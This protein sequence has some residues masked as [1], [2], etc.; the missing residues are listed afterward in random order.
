MSEMSTSAAISAL[1][2]GERIREQH[3]W[4]DSECCQLAYELHSLQQPP[5]S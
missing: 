4:S 1:E 3:R 2:K 5:Q